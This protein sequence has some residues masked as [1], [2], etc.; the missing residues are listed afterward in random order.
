MAP[1][2]IKRTFFLAAGWMFLVLGAVGIVV[3]LLPTTPFLLLA[4]ACFVRGSMRMHQW[5]VRHPWFGD[6][7]R[8]YERYRAVSVR[9]KTVSIAA[10]WTVIGFTAWFATDLWW[11]RITLAVIAVSVTIYL[12]SLKTVTKEMIDHSREGGG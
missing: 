6:Y 2:S 3:P 8:N 10:L 11:V 1:H 9:A 4:A 12:L 7:I 5:L